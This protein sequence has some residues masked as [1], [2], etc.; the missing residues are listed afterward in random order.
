VLDRVTIVFLA[1][2]QVLFLLGWVKPWLALP[3]SILVLAGAYRA[4]SE[5]PTPPAGEVR[6]AAVA[7]I[8]GLIVLVVAYSGAGGYAEPSAGRSLS[9]SVARDLTEYAWPIAYPAAGSGG[10]VA[11]LASPMADSLVPAAFGKLL[12]RDAARHL[13]FLWAVLGVSL[14]TFGF[15]RLVGRV[16]PLYALLFLFFGGLDVLGLRITANLWQWDGTEPLAF[17]MDFAARRQPQGGFLDGVRWVYL[18]NADAL[19]FSAGDV[20]GCWPALLVTMH[21]AIRRRTCSRAVFLWSCCLLYSPLTFLGMVPF[22]A[23]AIIEA[24]GAGLTS[25]QNTA[26]SVV[27]LLLA[28][29]FLASGSAASH[30][31]LWVFQNV[32][33]SWPTLLLFYLVEFGLYAVVWPQPEAGRQSI[34]PVWRWTAIACLLAAPWYVFMP[35][36]DFTMKVS[37]PA[38]LVFQVALAAALAGARSGAAR[39]HAVALAVFLVFGAFSSITNVARAV[40]GGWTLSAERAE[41]VAHVDQIDPKR[42]APLPLSNGDGFFWRRLARAP[43]SR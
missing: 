19:Y 34:A 2:P 17:W 41:R 26:A 16:S 40:N 14:A 35:R 1:A 42:I 25:F 22:L 8:L 10:E 21:D 9:D 43:R 11:V 30:G 20:L 7:S 18:S 39:R 13:G 5:N 24:R 36:N 28:G 33:Q 32:L 15:L 6:A 23:V 12:G 29:S 38:L 31:P 4:M 27:I 37:L 3:A